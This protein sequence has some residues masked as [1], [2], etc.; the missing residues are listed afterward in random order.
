M[1]TPSALPIKVLHSCW[2]WLPLTQNW[3]YSQI[4][5]LPEA[6]IEAHVACQVTENVSQFPWRNLHIAKPRG[7]V[8][9][10]SDFLHRFIGEA[11]KGHTH[12]V[13]RDTGCEILHSHFGNHAWHDLAAS[14]ALGIPHVA[15]FYGFDVNQL[16]R[17]SATWRRRYRELFLEISTVLC[18]GPHM[19]SCLHDLGCPAHKIRVMPLGIEIGE[20][21]FAPRQWSGKDPLRV[22][23]AAAFREKKGIPY[24]LAA[25]GRLARDVPLQITVVGDAGRDR[26][27]LAEKQRIMDGVRRAGLQTVTRMSGFV[28]HDA[29]RA[30][31]REHDVFV[32]PSITAADGDTEGGAP[33]AII[34]MMATGMPV[35]S[36]WHCDIPFVVG[37][38][39]SRFLAAERD[40]DDLERCLRALLAEP[41]WDVVT[42]PSRAH[43]AAQHDAVRQGEALAQLYRDVVGSR[44]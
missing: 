35:V 40:A 9:R 13:A 23:I 11:R 12:D 2:S 5:H 25:L 39:G 27:S 26:A 37:P 3:I 28:D 14:R 17:S 6:S 29:L 8:R 33:V 30:I 18:E 41:N 31:A 43:V 21:Q 34:E 42:Q 36:T 22:L 4:R 7:L 15:T 10:G 32:S 1:S 20:A 38:Q 44:S 24:A 19:A 16:P